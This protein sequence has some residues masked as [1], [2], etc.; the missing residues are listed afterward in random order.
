MVETYAPLYIVEIDGKE[1][2]EDI[3]QHI[4]SFTYEDHEDK[5]DELRLTIAKGDLAL[6]DHPQLQEGKEI[7]ARWGYVGNLSEA[8][9][10]TIKEIEYTFGEDGV[11]RM[12]VTALDKGH[13][14]TGRS[15]RTCWNNKQVADVV[16]DIAKKNNLTPK[17]DI[18]EDITQE[19]ISQGG[20]SDMDFLKELARDM[21]CSVWVTN[22][23]LYFEPNKVNEPVRTFHWREDKDGYLKSLRITSNA[24][25]GKGTGR[26]TE[27]AGLDPLT[28]KPIKET[29]S[30]K[31][32]SNG[33][34]DVSG[35]SMS[36]VSAG[37]GSLPE[38]RT[39]NETPLQAKHDEA[40]RVVATPVSTAA[41][42]RR[43]G[44][45]KVTSA[46]MQAIEATATAIGLPYLKAKDTV[47]IENIGKKFSG[48]WRIKSV[49]HS[50]SSS[51][52]T[53]ELT[54]C[55]SNYK[56]SDSKKAGEAPKTTAK[57]GSTAKPAGA[58]GNNKKPPAKSVLVDGS[59]VKE[60]EQ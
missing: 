20:K 28:K 10:C 40:G 23:E 24:E 59:E 53:C 55:K 50:I 56:S 21:G 22:D 36:E 35:S 25:K 60:V 39:E 29:V 26:G 38:R 45:G 48:D 19:F 18:P 7:R 41:R 34:V 6:V 57:S 47:T 2:A 30:A 49:R 9:T 5:M 54:L 3:S 52:Y 33:T 32:N 46:S 17:V 42:A 43:S 58:S 27:V 8:R 12:E 44:K 51:G 14:L 31:G 11:A 15:A 16:K 13:K 4:E 37:G 1:L